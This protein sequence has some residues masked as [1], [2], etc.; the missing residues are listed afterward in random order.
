M[1]LR[2]FYSMTIKFQN[3]PTILKIGKTHLGHFGVSGTTS[4][5]ED[6]QGFFS[7]LVQ[8][9][10]FDISSNPMVG[11]LPNALHN[12]VKLKLDYLTCKIEELPDVTVEHTN[13]LADLQY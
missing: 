6:L 9:N 2:Q 4:N 10:V 8:L 11:K 3:C 5:E 7:G 1:T 12:L 13:V